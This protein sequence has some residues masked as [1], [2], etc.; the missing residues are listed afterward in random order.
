MEHP[1]KT[2]V[3]SPKNL[4]GPDPSE[5]L[6]EEY[7]NDKKVTKDTPRSIIFLCSD[8]NV[9]NPKHG[10]TYYSQCNLKGV[11][12]SLHVYPTGGHGWGCKSSFK[13]RDQV[14]FELKKWLE[15]F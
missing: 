6:L 3:Q 8:D 4:M 5:E 15:S 7:S 14:L 12:T 10:V 2:T 11:S 1:S 13:F 9:V